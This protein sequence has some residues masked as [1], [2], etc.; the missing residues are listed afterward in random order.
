MSDQSIGSSI[1]GIAEIEKPK[2]KIIPPNTDEQGRLPC[3]FEEGPLWAPGA[4]GKFKE[5]NGAPNWCAAFASYCYRKG[6]EAAGKD[7][8]ALDGKD[9]KG[10]PVRWKMS[11]KASD[12]KPIFEKLGLFVP[13]DQV[14][15]GGDQIRADLA[16]LPGEGDLV[17]WSVHA[18]LLRGFKQDDKGAWWMHTIEG[19][20][21]I[22]ESGRKLWGVHNKKYQV[23][24]IKNLLGFGLGGTVDLTAPR[25]ANS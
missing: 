24:K 9:A 15:S 20:T 3:Y 25:Q 2:V 14:F 17:I 16:R 11:A 13:A 23:G 1:I 19:N 5:K 21:Y 18:G 4:W 22:E 7:L 12:N 6:Y 8:R 10:K